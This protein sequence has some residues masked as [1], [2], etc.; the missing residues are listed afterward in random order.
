VRPERGKGGGVAQGGF[1]VDRG[2]EE[3]AEEHGR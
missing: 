1:A 3:E 2:G